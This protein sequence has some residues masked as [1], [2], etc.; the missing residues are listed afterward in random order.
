MSVADRAARNVRLGEGVVMQRRR[1]KMSQAEL[2][3]KVGLTRRQVQG[4]E[5]GGGCDSALL[6]QIKIALGIPLKLRVGR[7]AV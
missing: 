6:E 5:R 7:G 2:A 1:L 3:A 4:I